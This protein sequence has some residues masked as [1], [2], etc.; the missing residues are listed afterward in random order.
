MQAYIILSPGFEE[1]EAITAIDILRRAGIGA[2]TVSLNENAA[3]MGSHNIVVM[4]DRVLSELDEALGDAL[5]LP[6][7]MKGVENML[8]SEALLSLVS[9][10]HAA[11]AVIAAVCAAPL[12]L[13]KLG[14]LDSKQFTCHPC[15]YERLKS[16]GVQNMPMLTDGQ[17]VTGRSAGC[18]MIWSLALVHKL[19]G[20]YP[21]GLLKGLRL[22]KDPG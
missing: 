12:V 16:K 9:K 4:A 1:V 14:L 11:D 5:V 22:E 20:G 8:A 2:T 6:G 15:V 21:D 7:G 3:V 10:Y 13:D 18:A 17:I 19:L